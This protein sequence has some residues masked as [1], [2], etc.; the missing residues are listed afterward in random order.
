MQKILDWGPEVGS[1]MIFFSHQF[2]PRGML[3]WS[4]KQKGVLQL[5]ILERPLMYEIPKNWTQR[6]M[7]RTEEF[8]VWKARVYES[9]KWRLSINEVFSLSLHKLDLESLQML[10]HLLHSADEP[11]YVFCQFTEVSIK[12]YSKVHVQ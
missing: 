5:D 12:S 6:T 3:Q 1:F 10:L 4:R 9:Q 2:E 11:R 8:A 7:Q